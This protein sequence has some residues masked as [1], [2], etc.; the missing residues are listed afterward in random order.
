MSEQRDDRQCDLL[1][2]SLETITNL[3]IRWCGSRPMAVAIGSQG[4]GQDRAISMVQTDLRPG[5]RTKDARRTKH[6]DDKD[7]FR[8]HRTSPSRRVWLPLG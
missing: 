7:R 2:P 8:F 5:G 6:F 3:R 1:Q 4:V